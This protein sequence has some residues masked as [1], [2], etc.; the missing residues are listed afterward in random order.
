MKLTLPIFF[1]TDAIQKLKDADIDYDIK[2]CDI[3]PV[4]FYRIDAIAPFIE[5]DK[6]TGYTCIYQGDSS[7]ICALHPIKVEEL[8]DASR[9]EDKI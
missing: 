5:H 7:F 1:Y 3:Y 9:R 8:I 6:K 4:I 2:Q